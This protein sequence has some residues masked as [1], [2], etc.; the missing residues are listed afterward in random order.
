[1][2]RQIV[3]LHYPAERPENWVLLKAAARERELRLVS[4]APHLLGLWCADGRQSACYAG[5]PARPAIVIHRTVAPFRGIAAP[6]LACLAAQGSLVLN[7][8]DAAFRSRDKLLTTVDLVNA[9][10]PVVPT[11]AFDEPA[12]ADLAALGLGELI[13]KPARGVR[14]EGIATHPLGRGP[15]RRVAAEG[16]VAPGRC[17]A[18]LPRRTGALPG[19]AA[20]RRRRP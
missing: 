20:D 8:P 3:V 19:A 16:G 6:V 11:A 13:V 5:R 10:I 12:G 15:H 2:T 17:Q 9:G 7:H 4:W 18:G 14:G 1:M